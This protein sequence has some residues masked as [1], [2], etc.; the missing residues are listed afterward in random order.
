MKAMSMF[1]SAGIGESRLNEIGI[2]V[3][4]ASELIEERVE[5]YKK[6]N[7][8]HNIT[9]GDIR[10]PLVFEQFIQSAHFGIDLLIATPPCQGVSIAG[11]NRSKSS[12][13]EDLRNHLIFAVIDTIKRV[14][15]NR[16]LIENVPQYLD[17]QLLDGE[18]WKTVPALL[19]E[20]FENQY[21]VSSRVLDS[22]DF[23]VPQVR[24]R[25]FIKMTRPNDNWPWPEPNNYKL[26]VRDA[27][28]D[29]PSLESGE[30]S[31][32][33]LHYARVHDP[34]HVEWMANTPTGKTAFDNEVFFPAR[35][36]GTKIRAF[37]STYR[38][39]EWDSPA[40]AI[41]MRNDAISSQRNVHPGREL[42]SGKW[43]DA[44]VLT[45]R[46]LL[47]L[48]GM[49]PE[50]FAEMQIDE[51]LLRRAIGEGVPPLMMNT[52]LKTGD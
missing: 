13:S 15:P 52:I 12:Q 44:R 34:R 16:V 20:I 39:M 36:D 1:S 45:P 31:G 25:S 19:E 24:R 18:I 7:R 22:S 46:E 28:G 50:E 37:R 38:R 21:S 43:S 26:S 29:L 6:I 4:S 33:P 2:E 40:P 3:I 51:N 23:G 14:R 35:K 9:S 42:S 8:G 41:T 27:I 49:K 5:L 17:L 10:D 30:D 32:I 47:L 11:K 48:N